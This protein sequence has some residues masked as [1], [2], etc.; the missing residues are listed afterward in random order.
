MVFSGD[1]YD[2]VGQGNDIQNA[3]E[4]S[5]WVLLGLGGLPIGVTYRE[6]VNFLKILKNWGGAGPKCAKTRPGPKP[7]WGPKITKKDKILH[8][9]S[10]L[11]HKTVPNDSND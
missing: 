1:Y 4:R 9:T 8:I 3:G 11:N 6:W 2:E 7:T 5:P 10:I